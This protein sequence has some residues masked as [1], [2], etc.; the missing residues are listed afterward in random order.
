MTR[1]QVGIVGV[2]DIAVEHAKGAIA[3]GFSVAFAIARSESARLERFK[4][5]F[6]ATV[7]L[8]GD[9]EELLR[10]LNPQVL[11]L[12]I[13]ASEVPSYISRLRHRAWTGILLIEKPGAVNSNALKSYSEELGDIQIYF[14]YNRRF[15]ASFAS[16]R[17]SL[18][19]DDPIFFDVLIGES[20]GPTNSLPEKASRICA[21]SVHILDLL[22]MIDRQIIE[23][24]VRTTRTRDDSFLLCDFSTER[25]TFR[26]SFSFG[27]PVLSSVQAYSKGQLHRLKPIEK[28]QI[29]EGIGSIEPTAELPIRSYFLRESE[30]PTL[31]LERDLKPGFGR[32]WKEVANRQSSREPQA[33]ASSLCSLKEAVEVLNLAE[34]IALSGLGHGYGNH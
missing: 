14:A 26:L 31:S 11:V 25:N 32:M 30:V 12:A 15:Y 24:A 10:E 16:F 22:L 28:Y 1:P 13:P 34:T 6:N 21:N 33:Q 29:F 27:Q 23:T 5:N 9:F 19:K 20:G 17:E 2:S 7:G 3:A 8:A 18:P 4:N